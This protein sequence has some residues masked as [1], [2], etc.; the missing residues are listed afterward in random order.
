MLYSE[1]RLSKDIDAFID[2]PQYLSL[3]SPRLGGE[4]IWACETFDETAHDLKLVYPEGE[5]DFIVAGS[6]TGISAESK[7]IDM[8]AIRAGSSCVVDVEHPVEIALKKLSYRGNLLKIRDVFDIAVVDFLHSGLLRDNLHHVTH[9]KPGISER[10][11]GIQ[12][13]FFLREIEELAIL[14]RWRPLA[15]N[16]LRRLRDIVEEMPDATLTRPIAS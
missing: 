13:E 1:H 7:A 12:E 4:D 3:L 6:I 15:V 2:D 9:L 11:R 16:S 10:L 8:D 14:D 5:I